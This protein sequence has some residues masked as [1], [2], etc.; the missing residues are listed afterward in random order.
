MAEFSTSL[1]IA[2]ATVPAE[3]PPGAGRTDDR[4]PAIAGASRTIAMATE[5]RRHRL[6]MRA[7][8]SARW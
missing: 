6:G 2:L 1:D 7:G 4:F 8:T 3:R 5:R